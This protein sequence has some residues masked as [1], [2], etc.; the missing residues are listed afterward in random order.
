[1]KR[2]ALL[3]FLLLA[4]GAA[5]AQVYKWVDAKGVTHYSDQPPP[6]STPAKTKVE[7]KSFSGGSSIADLPPELAEVV[8]NRPVTLYTT[9]QCEGCNQARAMLLARGVPF[10]EKTVT[11]SQ[12]QAVL[13]KA[14]SN[15]QL[16]LL[17]VGRS[18]QIGYEQGSWEV[19]LS[20]AGY[21]TQKILPASY[22]NPAPVPAAP[23]P[24]PDAAAQARA[25]ALAAQEEAARLQRPPAVNAP[26]GFQF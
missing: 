26:P 9:D 14:G 8:R 11:T 1:M 13:K 2:T 19:L 22:S 16:P 3:M 23:P 12:D 6:P 25:A 24:P 17:L 5:G 18:K 20:D 21:P 15:G 4:A 10:S 7:V